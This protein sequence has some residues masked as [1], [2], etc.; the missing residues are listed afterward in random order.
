[1]NVSLTQTKQ[2][3]SEYLDIPAIRAGLIV[4]FFFASAFLNYG[5]LIILFAAY[6]ALVSV[7]ITNRKV[8]RVRQGIQFL[9][10][11]T[12]VLVFGIAFELCFRAWK[13]AFPSLPTT[14]RALA[15][16]TL[17][18]VLLT[19]KFILIRNIVEAYSDD[20]WFVEK[21]RGTMHVFRALIL[22]VAALVALVAAYAGPD[23]SRIGEFLLKT[24]VPG[25]A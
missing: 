21:L 18:G 20:K 14:L 1:M 22:L 16:L 23:G 24:A 17:A 13:P 4:L 19:T 15:W 8:S 5:F 11:E 10:F 25:I 6:V 2:D 3:W 12:A 7:A 9:S